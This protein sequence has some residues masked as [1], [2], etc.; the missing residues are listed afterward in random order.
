M[1]VKIG[2]LAYL[3]RGKNYGLIVHVL[4]V[5]DKEGIL[6]NGLRYIQSE[7]PAWIV[8]CARPIPVKFGN[9]AELVTIGPVADAALRPIRDQ[10]GEDEILTIAGKPISE[11]IEVV[12]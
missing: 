5:A 1:N 10:P 8:E 4:A 7:L 12:A 6:P 11:N 9:D 3:A 2:D